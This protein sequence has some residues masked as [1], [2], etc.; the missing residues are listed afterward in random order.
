[1]NCPV[2][3]SPEHD[4]VH[5]GSFYLL[6]QCRACRTNFQERTG[7][8][9]KRYGED[10][11]GANHRKTYG[12]TYI[13]DEANIRAIAGRRLGILGSM[14]PAGGRILDI[15]SALGI[16]CDEAAR[17]GF[18][19]EGVEISGYAR[20]F[21]KKTFGVVSH[22][23]IGRVKGPFDALTLWYTIEHVERP[24]AFLAAALPLLNANGIIA[25]AVPNGAGA[26]ARFNREKYYAIRPEEH[27]FEPSPRGMKLLLAEHG[28]GI[29]RTE[30]FGL[31]PDRVGLPDRQAVRSLQKALR[32]GDTFEVYAAASGRCT[33]RP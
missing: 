2:C 15:G 19:A 30:F 20:K 4:A 21:A 33:A 14:I 8:P 31:H 23:D 1:V 5:E 3:D 18:G 16:F 6:R 32:L 12:T 13:E 9:E 11:F 25:I 10:Y 26:C 22:P 29:M 7:A 28:C 17:R 27:F 24:R